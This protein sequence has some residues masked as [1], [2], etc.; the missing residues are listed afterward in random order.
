MEKNS[1]KNIIK[2]TL[3]VTIISA[4]G[5][6]GFHLFNINFW[7]SFLLLFVIQ[8]VVFSF[9]STTINNY[10]TQL[11]RQKELDMLEPLSTFL[12]CAYCKM[13]NLMTFLPDQTERIELECEFCNKKNL[14]SISFN[15]ARLTEP[16][17]IPDVARIPLIDEKQ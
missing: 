13:I 14:V 17:N 3:M 10:Y 9:I 7:A 11:T 12:E 1:L 4:I 8:Y 15:V 16:V 6:L 2:S 5:A